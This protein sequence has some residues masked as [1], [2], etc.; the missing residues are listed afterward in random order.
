MNV[1]TTSCTPAVYLHG[2]IGE[3][4][5]ELL[6]PAGAT[7]PAIHE[8]RRYPPS[9]PTVCRKTFLANQSGTTTVVPRF[10][11]PAWVSSRNRS[12]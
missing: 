2:N 5:H 4:L 3:A 11:T 7:A 8:R 10:S 1:T 12:Q 9:P 6:S